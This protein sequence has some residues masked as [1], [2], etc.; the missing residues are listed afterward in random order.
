MTLHSLCSKAEPAWER[1]FYSAY[2]AEGKDG[3]KKT[4]F[5]YQIPLNTDL[6]MVMLQKCGVSASERIR[7]YEHILTC[8]Q[9]QIEVTA[10]LAE[11]NVPNVLAFSNLEQHREG[12][13]TYLYLETEEVYPVTERIF[14]SA[15]SRIELLDLLISLSMILRDL[16]DLEIGVTHRGF[17][18]SEVYLDRDNKILLG[19]FYYAC[20][21]KLEERDSD[22]SAY[23]PYFPLAPAHLTAQ[24]FRGESGSCGQDIQMLAQVGWNLFS[25][26]PFDAEHVGSKNVFPEYATEEIAE[27]LL[28]GLS[29]KEESCI[30][31]CNK[32]LECR[33]GL[34]KD[35]TEDI[36]VPISVARRKAYREEF[37]Q[38]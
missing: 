18:L 5:C 2:L 12:N 34:S 1:D 15:C 38:P 23:P 17:D 25:G 33:K 31:F 10:Y 24:L 7:L 13:T 35:Q 28:L 22:L 21:P 20:G 37:I 8:V 30:A 27:A 6:E 9:H 36:P 3:I 19:G 32:I 26:E 16:S 11:K 29:G 14:R 4:V